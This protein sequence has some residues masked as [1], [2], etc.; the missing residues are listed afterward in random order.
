MKITPISALTLLVCCL[1]FFTSGC[2]VAPSA[3]PVQSEAA[4]VEV[5]SPRCGDPSRLADTISFYNWAEYID[6]EIL[7]MFEE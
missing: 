5:V 1:V 4:A 6:P 7:A 3:A 2:T